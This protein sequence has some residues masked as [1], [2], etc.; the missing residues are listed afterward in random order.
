MSALTVNVDFLF[1]RAY[2]QIYVS[3]YLESKFLIR[4]VTNA[5]KQQNLILRK[6]NHCGEERPTN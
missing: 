3:G 1:P 5:G 6:I 4:N 2:S